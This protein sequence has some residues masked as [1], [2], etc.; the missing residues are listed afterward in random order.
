[1]FK[2]ALEG[3]TELS[4]V[5]ILMVYYRDKIQITIN[6]GKRHMGRGLGD[7]R[8]SFQHSLPVE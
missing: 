7:S 3:L 1:M 2:N 8:T 6:K 4:K 5:V